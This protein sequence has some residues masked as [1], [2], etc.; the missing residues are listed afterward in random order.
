[1]FAT[2]IHPGRVRL[3]TRLSEWGQPF[4][5]VAPL[6]RIDQYSLLRPVYAI[7]SFIFA[8]DDGEGVEDVG[9]IVTFETR[10]YYGGIRVAIFANFAILPPKWT[11]GS[12]G[13]A[14][15]W[16]ILRAKIRKGTAA[17]RRRAAEWA[18][19]RRLQA[20]DAPLCKIRH[21]CRYICHKTGKIG[22]ISEN[23]WQHGTPSSYKSACRRHSLRS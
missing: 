20:R 22:A 2:G 8:P 13:A 21:F 7:G 1:M 11:A 3:R 15:K 14:T 12:R 10:N 5:E 19:T 9:G 17:D 16:R 6:Q 23:K 4:A 18:K